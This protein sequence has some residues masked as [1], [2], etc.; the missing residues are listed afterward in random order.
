MLKGAIAPLPNNSLSQSITHYIVLI[1]AI[2]KELKAEED[3]RLLKN[4]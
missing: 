4:S 2:K 3:N 1:G